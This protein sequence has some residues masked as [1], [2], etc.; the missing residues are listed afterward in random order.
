[1]PIGEL[2][3]NNVILKLAALTIVSTALVSCTETPQMI[4]DCES[5]EEL[6]V[7]CGYQNPED[8]AIS[9][10]GQHLIVSQ[11]GSMDGSISG[12]L[13]I[14]DFEGNVSIA[15]E[16]GKTISP[17]TSWGSDHCP[18]GPAAAFSP[19]G[20]DLEKRPDGKWQLL[21]VNHGGRES[22][23][24]FELSEAGDK[25]VLTWRGCVVMPEEIHLNDVVNMNS[26]GFWATHMYPRNSGVAMIRGLLGAEIGHVVQWQEGMGL[27]EVAGS[28]GAFPNGI[29]KSLDEK[30]LFVNH[31]ISGQTIKLEIETDR[32]SVV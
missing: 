14:S 1:M 5:T 22:V 8:L 25:P 29:E 4:S 26:G 9:P 7:F 31:Y 18:G 16:G 28:K 19:H 15:F 20:L 17:T 30:F 2:V 10:R 23:E 6:T 24:Y 12:N 3:M 27:T 32:K 21:V 11:F 13:A